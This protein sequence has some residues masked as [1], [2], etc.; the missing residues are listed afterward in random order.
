MSTVKRAWWGDLRLWYHARTYTEEMKRTSLQEYAGVEREEN[1]VVGRSPNFASRVEVATFFA[2]TSDYTQEAYRATVAAML[3]ALAS[4][5]GDASPGRVLVWVK[6][7][8][9]AATVTSYGAPTVTCGGGHPFVNGDRVHIPVLDTGYAYGSVSNVAGN[10]F[11]LTVLEG[12]LTP[13]ATHE[14]YL[15]E[16]A[17]PGWFHEGMAPLARGPKGDFYNPEA[18]YS[19][20]GSRTNVYT[21]TSVD[22]GADLG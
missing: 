13:A 19:F 17:W 18:R 16:R 9:A 5:A 4:R 10:N 22:L 21:R 7:H 15:V 1:L 14:V 2:P 11:D 20:R 8:T 12:S 3:D 6:D